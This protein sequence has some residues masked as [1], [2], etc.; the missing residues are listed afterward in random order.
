M[1]NVRSRGTL[2]PVSKYHGGTRRGSYWAAASAED[3]PFAGSGAEDGTDDAGGHGKELWRAGSPGAGLGGAHHSGDEPVAFGARYSGGDLVRPHAAGPVARVCHTE[4]ECRRALEPATGSLART[5]CSRFRSET[6][7]LA[8]LPKANDPTWKS[9]MK[10]VLM[11]LASALV[12]R[13]NSFDHFGP[14]GS[15]SRS[16]RA[17]MRWASSWVSI[18]R[19]RPS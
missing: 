7:D 8:P 14:V 3:P 15:L 6:S 4:T 12:I 16:S 10:S 1:A 17:L 11:S 9:L 13:G 19:R 18:M 2:Q 5:G